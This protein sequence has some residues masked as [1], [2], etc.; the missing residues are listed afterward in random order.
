MGVKKILVEAANWTGA[1]IVIGTYLALASGWI[2]TATY[3]W[4]GLLGAVLIST[5]CWQLRVYPQVALNIVWFLIS[6]YGVWR[7]L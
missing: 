7:S 1:V 3:C 4:F 5:A 2:S 6:L